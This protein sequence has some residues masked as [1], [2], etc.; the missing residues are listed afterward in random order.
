LSKFES[1]EKTSNAAKD[2]NTKMAFL[3]EVDYSDDEMPPPTT[4]KDTQDAIQTLQDFLDDAR[5]FHF[6]KLSQFERFINSKY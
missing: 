3:A 1:P 2:I 6:D 5:I 4:S